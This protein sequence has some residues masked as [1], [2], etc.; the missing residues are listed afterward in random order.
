MVP[1][2]IWRGSY[3]VLEGVNSTEGEEEKAGL[4]KCN[5]ASRCLGARGRKVRNTST[6]S[7]RHDATSRTFSAWRVSSVE[8]VWGD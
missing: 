2:S 7:L 8:D 4:L 5:I 6:S 1:P 3:G